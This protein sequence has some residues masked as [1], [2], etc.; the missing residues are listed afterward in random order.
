MPELKQARPPKE[1]SSDEKQRME[2]SRQ[3]AGRWVDIYRA[4]ERVQGDLVGLW[5]FARA[6]GI[7]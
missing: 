6:A 5:E 4:V 2:A 1:F 3:Y 7:A